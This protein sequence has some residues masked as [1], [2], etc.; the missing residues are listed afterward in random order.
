MMPFPYH[1]VPFH[2]NLW[3]AARLLPLYTRGRLDRMLRRATPPSSARAKGEMPWDEIVHAVKRTVRN[4]WRMRGRRC[5]REGLLAFHYLKSA[6]YAPVLRFGLS[7]ASLSQDRPRAHCWITLGDTCVLN[8]PEPGM[9][10]VFAYD[11]SLTEGVVAQAGIESA[12][13][14]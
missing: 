9:V 8:P 12:R 10:E 7:P 6:G 5:L 11:G 2:A 1:R 4:P 13:Y 14:D 3:I